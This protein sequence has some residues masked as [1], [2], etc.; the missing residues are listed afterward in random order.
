[1]RLNSI[2]EDP[3]L[4]YINSGSVSSFAGIQT[5]KLTASQVTCQGGSKN[6][7]DL[8]AIASEAQQYESPMNVST[9]AMHQDTTRIHAHGQVQAQELIAMK[10]ELVALRAEVERLTELV[11]LLKQTM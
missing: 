11:Q 2:S 5:E 9:A 8:C 3:F 4:V 6:I 10:Q 7:T 1:M